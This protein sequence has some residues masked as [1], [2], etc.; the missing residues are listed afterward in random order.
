M[1]WLLIEL[2]KNLQSFITLSTELTKLRWF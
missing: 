1:H 2:S